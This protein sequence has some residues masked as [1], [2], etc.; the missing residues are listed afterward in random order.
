MVLFCWQWSLIYAKRVFSILCLDFYASDG[1]QT[2]LAIDFL[3]YS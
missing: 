2:I 1:F 3:S